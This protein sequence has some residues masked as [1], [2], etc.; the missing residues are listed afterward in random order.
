M[1]KAYIQMTGKGYSPS[2]KWSIFGE[3]K[4]SANS[5]KELK[6]VLADRYGKSWKHK[7]PMYCDKKDGSTMQTGYVI[8][9]RADEGPANKWIQQDWVSFVEC[10]PIEWKG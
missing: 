10:N 5:L 9:F 2:A 6:G 3:D 1:Y 8:G 4:I 7:K